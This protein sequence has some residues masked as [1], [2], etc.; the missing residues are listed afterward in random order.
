MTFCFCSA[1]L[2][3][4]DGLKEIAELCIRS[5][6]SKSIIKLRLD[7]S[8]GFMFLMQKQKVVVIPL[9]MNKNFYNPKFG[10]PVA[11]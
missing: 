8:E 2:G 5:F 9:S 3:C 10:G 4:K 11:A 6:C 1:F 7:C